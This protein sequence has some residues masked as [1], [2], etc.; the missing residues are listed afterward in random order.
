MRTAKCCMEQGIHDHFGCD[1]S[2]LESILDPGCPEKPQNFSYNVVLQVH[3]ECE[4][5]L[6]GV[7]PPRA[8][9][10]PERVCERERERKRA[11]QLG[12]KSGL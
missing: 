12:R 10:K 11:Y 4:G 1:L 2:D 9:T 7:P 5:G 8:Q 3:I 6:V